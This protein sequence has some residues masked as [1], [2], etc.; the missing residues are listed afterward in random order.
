MQVYFVINIL[1]ILLLF[2]N[3]ITNT[4]IP[5]ANVSIHHINFTLLN[6]SDL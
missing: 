4:F 6:N 5:V 2:Y 3:L 1:F